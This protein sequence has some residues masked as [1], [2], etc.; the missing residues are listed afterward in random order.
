MIFLDNASTTRVLDEVQN[1]VNKYNTE[2]FY[3]PSALY[4]EAF[5]VNKD[6][7]RARQEIIKRLGGKNTDNLIFTSCATESNNMALKASIKKHTKALISIGEHPSVYK[8]ALD[9]KN[10]G[11]DIEFLPLNRDGCV[12]IDTFRKYMT[13][14]VDFVSIMHVNNETGAINDIEQLVRVARSINSKVVFHCDGVQAFGKINVNVVQLG[15]DFYTI[16]GHKIHAPKGIGALYVKDSRHIKPLLIGGGQES[17]YRSGTENVS[18]IIALNKASE[19]AVNNMGANY[20]HVKQLSE[21][22]RN[23]VKNAYIISKENA[24][25]YIM[26]LGFSGCRAETILHMVEEKGYLIGNGSACSSKKKENRN[27]EAI[28]YRQDIIE[29]AVRISFAR[30]TK[31]ED[32]KNFVEV[33]NNTV[34]E[35]LSKV[36]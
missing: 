36:R 14:E 20:E 32:V 24:S 3:N 33:L 1:I 26:M 15:V 7:N 16:S 5:S 34:E 10:N 25:P 8:L 2:N 27:L 4:G 18:G 31:L 35:Y 13:P 21:Y 12:D 9:L 22:V 30:D 28:G 17:E 19:V 23:N 11:H 6:I 29:G